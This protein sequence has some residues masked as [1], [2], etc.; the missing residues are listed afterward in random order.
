MNNSF[1]EIPQA[2]SLLKFDATID[3]YCLQR[4]TLLPLIFDTLKS[5]EKDGIDV[6]FLD[7]LQKSYTENIEVRLVQT[8]GLIEN[9]RD[10]QNE[11]LSSV[12]SN[13]ICESLQAPTEREH[14]IVDQIE[15]NL[16][17]LVGPNANPCD[18]GVNSSSVGNVKKLLVHDIR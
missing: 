4:S 11:R 17:D 12:P 8:A 9:L 5:L 7:S 15:G 2:S 6:S 1:L 13:N 10:A 16:K 3:M 14:A 18:L